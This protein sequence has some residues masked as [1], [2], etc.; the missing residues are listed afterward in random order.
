MAREKPCHQLDRNVLDAEG[1]LKAK[2]FDE[3]EVDEGPSS[4]VTTGMLNTLLFYF[5]NFIQ[6]TASDVAA[7][8]IPIRI[9]EVLHPF[10]LPAA[11]PAFGD[12]EWEDWTQSVVCEDDASDL[13][14]VTTVVSAPL[15][16]SQ[17]DDALE[18]EL[19]RRSQIDRD[20][21]A[22]KL[23]REDFISE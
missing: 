7:P 17:L 15:E 2:G 13:Q 1:A 6:G 4:S 14:S 8:A 16:L 5:P 23:D 22:S 21:F 3:P 18:A 10:H 9:D 19:Q 12:D 11:V 20:S